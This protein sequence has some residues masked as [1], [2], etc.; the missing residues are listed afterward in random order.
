MLHYFRNVTFVTLQ[1]NARYWELH[2]LR[3]LYNGQV[4]LRFVTGYNALHNGFFNT[5]FVIRQLC[6]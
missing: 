5:L 2:F 3:V 6:K 1:K 4:P